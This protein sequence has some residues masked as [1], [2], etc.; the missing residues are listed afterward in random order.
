MRRGTRRTEREATRQR[1]AES[2]GIDFRGDRDRA[3]RSK[4][5]SARSP[6]PSTGR[7]S[8]LTEENLQA[9]PCA[10]LLMALSNK[11]GWLVMHDR[12][13]V[14]VHPTGLR[15]ALRRHGR[16]LRAL[17]GRLQDGC[18][19]ARAATEPGAPSSELIPVSIIDRA[20]SA[21]LP[22]RP[23]RR[24]LAAAPY[25]DLDRVLAAYVEL[26]RSREELADDGFDPA[27]VEQALA[28]MPSAQ[29][30]SAARLLQ[31]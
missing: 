20:P 2:L 15:D 22:A 11:F 10:T 25:A 21:R 30:T 23:A 1:L 9:D 29:S 31:A 4:R 14:E 12:Q 17:E 5:S 13:Q 18:V 7:D 3:G 6:K 24:V 27:L 26:D 28:M 19:P 16:R 8:D